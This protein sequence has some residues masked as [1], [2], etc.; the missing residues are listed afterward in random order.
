[1]AFWNRRKTA[2]PD[3]ASAKLA[4]HVDRA[5]SEPKQPAVAVTTS[6]D[7]DK[8]VIQV[9]ASALLIGC[10]IV[11]VGALA[12]TAVVATVNHA[13]TLSTVALALA[14]IA[15]LVQIVVYVAQAGA[16]EAQRVHAEQL[17]A[18]TS[19]LLAEVKV[20][21]ASTQQL[22]QDQFRELLRAFL[23][24]A[25]RTAEEAKIDP[26][27]LEQ[28]LLQNVRAQILPEAE[29]ALAVE[30]A[31]EAGRSAVAR[32]RA[33]AARRPQ[34]SLELN[35]R[36]ED[37]RTL[38]DEESGKELLE[39]L[40]RLPAAS[41]LRLSRLGTDVVDSAQSGMF[42]GLGFD[43]GG[44]EA[45]IRDGLATRRRTRD[46]DGDLLDLTTLTDDGVE[47]ARLFTAEG[48]LPR[49]LDLTGIATDDDIPF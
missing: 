49:W 20:T 30:R 36:V 40:R 25:A 15:F 39:R 13:D 33:A 22:V 9:G 41:Q 2:A 24:G 17:N 27:R 43:R 46:S 5:G 19:T 26:E 11:T 16:A 35:P 45:L 7:G 10:G 12:A 4:G 23:G 47:M 3:G 37:L 8:P 38:P 34:Q 21:A 42:E 18:Q 31:R 48:E 6:S 14:V 44:D 1:L 28:R 29:R 32:R